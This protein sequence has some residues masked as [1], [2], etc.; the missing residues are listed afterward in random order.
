MFIPEHIVLKTT[1]SA[2]FFACLLIKW[3]QM[4]LFVRCYAHC[5]ANQKPLQVLSEKVCFYFSALYEVYI[6]TRKSVVAM[7]NLNGNCNMKMSDATFEWPVAY[8][9]M[10]QVH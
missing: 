5:F 4:I 6:I 9:K 10:S 1:F 2:S 8:D 3:M 7:E